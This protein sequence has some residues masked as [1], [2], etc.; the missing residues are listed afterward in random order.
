MARRAPPKRDDVH[1]HAAS[2]IRAL[3][4]FRSRL[5]QLGSPRRYL[6]YATGE[7]VLIVIGILLALAINN[8]NIA[9]GDRE[10]ETK[11]LLGIRIDLQ[12][13]LDSLRYNLDFRERRTASAQRLIAIM[14]G[15]Q[16]EHVGELAKDV[17]LTLYEERFT[18]SNVT[19]QDLISSGKMNLISNEQ[20]KAGLFALEQMYQTNLA[21]IDHETYE[22]REFTAR[23]IY[24]HADIERIKPVFLGE[25][26]AEQVGLLADDFTE[27]LKSNEYK[28]GCVVAV[29]TSDE[30]A[31]LHRKLLATSQRVIACIDA[32]LRTR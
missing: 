14:G 27:L 17:L 5:T 6:L 22:Y 21:Y 7:I 2:V 4:S 8:A 25:R 29:W 10:R 23:P 18:P 1:A 11:Y 20:L 32:E 16:A 26:T 9:R 13:D 12:K 3:K 19:V 24:R 15:A 30:F 31:E 28:N